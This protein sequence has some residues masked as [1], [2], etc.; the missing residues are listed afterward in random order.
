MAMKTFPKLL[1]VLL[2]LAITTR[3]QE[4]EKPA[5]VP[6]SEPAKPPTES[7]AKEPSTPAPSKAQP[8]APERKFSS[9]RARRKK[10]VSPKISEALK[11]KVGEGLHVKIRITVDEKGGV[12]EA[13]IQQTS[14]N[15]EFDAAALEAARNTP[16]LPRLEKGIPQ[17]DTVIQPYRLG[18]PKDPRD[19]V[20]FPKPEEKKDKK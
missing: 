7:P 8:A 4:G 6:A 3:G 19:L 20:V 16:F 2:A 5:P 11:A 10:D 9:D 1:S 17:K 13:V 15:A 18:L 12:E 14:G